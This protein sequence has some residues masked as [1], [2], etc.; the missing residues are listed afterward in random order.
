MYRIRVNLAHS[1]NAFW[2]GK[3]NIYTSTDSGLFMQCL[4]IDY[5]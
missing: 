4:L 2:V 1:G 3:Y 5:M